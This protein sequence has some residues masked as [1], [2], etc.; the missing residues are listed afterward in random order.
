MTEELIH[1]PC[2]VCSH[3]HA[4]LASCVRD[5]ETPEAQAEFKLQ[6]ARIRDK[7]NA[8][9]ASSVYPAYYA[10]LL[11]VIRNRARALGYTI[12]VHG[13]MQRDL[14]LIAVPW[15]PD[16]GSPEALVALIVDASGGY[17][18]HHQGVEHKPHGRLAWTIHLGGGPYIDLS[19]MPRSES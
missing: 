19:V 4:F 8:K 13:S 15:V 14:D 6:F 3:V 5:P 7:D 10:A 1:D 9:A 18:L 16:A 11:P 2:P 12:A 17:V